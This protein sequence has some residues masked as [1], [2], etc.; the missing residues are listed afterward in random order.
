M[1]T[2]PACLQHQSRRDPVE[3]HVLTRLEDATRL[4]HEWRALLEACSDASIYDTPE[5][6]LSSYKLLLG[7]R[8]RQFLV[9]FRRNGALIGLMPL[10]R[11]PIKVYGL[12]FRGISHVGSL[13]GDC[14]GIIGP[15]RPLLW[16]SLLAVL[17][18]DPLG[19][20]VLTL[21]EQAME[22]HE[23]I[24]G[25][26]DDRRFHLFDFV[27]SHRYLSDTEGT[28]DEYF[29][30]LASSS[31]TEIKRK[32]KKNEE[33][34]EPFRHEYHYEVGDEAS[35]MALL[36][37]Y[38]GIERK[39]W[40]IEAGV[41]ISNDPHTHSFYREFLS[42]LA[43]RRVASFWFLKDGDQDIAGL[44][45][46]HYRNTLYMAQTTFDP[47]YREFSPGL[48][49]T[50]GLLEYACRHPAIK[51]YDP[52]A[53]PVDQGRPRHKTVWA[54]HR[55]PIPTRKILVFRNSGLIGLIGRCKQSTVADVM[56]KIRRVQ[57]RIPRPT[58]GTRGRP[59]RDSRG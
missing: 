24:R 25:L 26:R 56:K 30:R 53:T 35:M 49:A 21:A 55:E 43:K 14:P 48:L 1:I 15:D 50:R 34:Q 27:E 18:S 33:R 57:V 46:Y 19:W 54:T 17:E 13:Q 31:R 7:A 8:E 38:V 42:R 4:E 51:R 45:G 9:A 29:A 23:L 22:D 59:E 36:D 20:D 58:A 6:V 52:L 5:F 39:T 40:K 2:A 10:Y 41:G 37:R 28:F 47:A 11:H 12:E 44:I 3:C 32:F 16:T